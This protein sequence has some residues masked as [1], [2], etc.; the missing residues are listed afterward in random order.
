MVSWDAQIKKLFKACK[1]W[2]HMFWYWILHGTRV[3]NIWQGPLKLNYFTQNI[4]ILHIN[5]KDRCTLTYLCT[6]RV[7]RCKK[8]AIKEQGL[9][10]ATNFCAAKVSTDINKQPESSSKNATKHLPGE[11]VRKKPQ[12]SILGL[13]KNACTGLLRDVRSSQTPVYGQRQFDAGFDGVCQSN[14]PS[15]QSL[16]GSASQRGSPDIS[17]TASW[18]PA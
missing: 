9:Y 16:I 10:F 2:C 3:W 5:R 15:F 1:S 6:V 18:Q 8:V 14:Q 4:T 17:S 12:W 13:F 7:N 11:A